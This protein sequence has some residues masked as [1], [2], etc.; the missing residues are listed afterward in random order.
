[1]VTRVQIEYRLSK[2]LCADKKL[3]S[4]LLD[5]DECSLSLDNCHENSN[6]TNINGSFVC[7]CERGHTGNGTVCEGIG[8]CH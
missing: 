8:H 2:Q 3:S 7:S 5:L 1:M 6:C 4:I